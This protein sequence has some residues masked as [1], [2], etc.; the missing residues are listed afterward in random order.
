MADALVELAGGV[1]PFMPLSIGAVA[2]SAG[3][4]AVAVAELGGIP[5]ALSAAFSSLWF[6]QPAAASSTNSAAA[7]GAVPGDESGF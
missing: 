4:G 7:S 6:L 2:V 5:A 3:M 1:V